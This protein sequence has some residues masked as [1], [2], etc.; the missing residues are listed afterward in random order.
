MSIS[1]THQVQ[2]ISNY[3]ECIQLFHMIDQCYVPTI[4]SPDGIWHGDDDIDNIL[5]WH[6]SI[7]QSGYCVGLPVCI[8]QSLISF[9]ESL[10]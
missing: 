7:D 6:D 3:K 4:V 8:V 5:D 2:I 10:Q 1:P 9:F